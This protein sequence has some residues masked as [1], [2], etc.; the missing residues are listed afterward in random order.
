MWFKIMC[1]DNLWFFWTDSN[2]INFNILTKYTVMAVS[3]I[4]ID[5]FI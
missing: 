5:I 2:G 3:N 1:G 4:F